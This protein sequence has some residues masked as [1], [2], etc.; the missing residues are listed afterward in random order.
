MKYVFT[1]YGLIFI[2]LFSTSDLLLHLML[3]VTTGAITVRYVRNQAEYHH[4]RTV[5]MAD[6]WLGWHISTGAIPECL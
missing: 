6:S 3:L 4:E 2:H 5:E 1:A